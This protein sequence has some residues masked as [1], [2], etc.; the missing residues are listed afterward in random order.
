MGRRSEEE[1]IDEAWAALDEG[2]YETAVDL[3]EQVLVRKP[4]EPDANHIAG[5]ALLEAGESME[6]I[7]HLERADAARPD[8]PEILVDLGCAR[9][10]GLLFRDARAALT[11]AL[12]LD[13]R[14][15]RGHHWL[16]LLEERE[17]NGRAAKTHFEKAEKLAPDAFP[18]PYRVT[19]TEFRSL[20]EEAIAELPEDFRASLSNLDIIVEPLPDDRTLSG[21]PPLSPGI[22]G[23]HVGY[24]AEERPSSGTAAGHLPNLIFLF[25]KNIERAARDHDELVDQVR[26]T[27]L[28]E[29]GHYLGLDEDEVEERGLE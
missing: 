28:H 10:E 26:V 14:L 3:A 11:R 12:S 16:G 18:P 27:L 1:L 2:D 23:L 6:A 15:A 17:G 13:K 5:A 20:V 24:S 22:L 29:I 19:E 4:N 21:N 9:F 25:Q 8:D 7:P